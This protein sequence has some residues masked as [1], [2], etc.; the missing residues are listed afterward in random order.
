MDDRIA[1]DIVAAEKTL[2]DPAIRRDSVALDRWLDPEFT[3]I[4]QAGRLW[5]RDEILADLLTT[6]QSVYAAA[7]LSEPLVRELA[8]NCYLLTYVVQI[9][10][11]R[12]CRS[13]IWRFQDGQ[14]RMA[15]NQG[16]PLP[17]AP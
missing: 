12:S 4:G 6:D 3:E 7:E 5:T 16:T 1:A 8:P 15:F 17:A 11:R 10:D 2:L 9:G 13:S 14:W